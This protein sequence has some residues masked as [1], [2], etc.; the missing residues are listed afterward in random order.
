MA[1]II[2][3]IGK[4]ITNAANSVADAV[5]TASEVT[6]KVVSKLPNIA[7]KAAEGAEKTVESVSNL[8]D[9][10]FSHGPDPS[11]VA[12]GLL[13]DAKSH[14]I[15][16]ALSDLAH[17][18]FDSGGG[19]EEVSSGT[20]AIPNIPEGIG[21]DASLFADVANQSEPSQLENLKEN[22]PEV[23]NDSVSPENVQNDGSN[24]SDEALADALSHRN[25]M[26]HPDHLLPM[27]DIPL[28]HH[29]VYS[30][31]TG[32]NLDIFQSL[33]VTS[34]S[35]FDNACK[36]ALEVYKANPTKENA[37]KLMSNLNNSSKNILWK[38][39]ECPH[40]IPTDKPCAQCAAEKSGK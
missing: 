36:E 40:G 21:D 38:E 31:S 9:A 17:G 1:N 15:E 5:E 33:S 35:L 27:A 19:M 20:N 12:D 39:K 23:M 8:G 30:D 4:G 6:E 7:E 26:I 28:I 29:T 11:E 14:G 32:G 24:V 13:G 34:K 3:P 2:D 16:G 25:S 37:Q 22:S 10:A 18:D